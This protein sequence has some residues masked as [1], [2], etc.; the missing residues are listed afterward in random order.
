MYNKSWK[1]KSSS[2]QLIISYV[3]DQSDNLMKSTENP[4]ISKCLH[5]FLELVIP[6]NPCKFHIYS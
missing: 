6:H 4:K 1:Q 2:N 5:K 3:Y